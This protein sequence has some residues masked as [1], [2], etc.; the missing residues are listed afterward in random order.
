MVEIPFKAIKFNKCQ[1]FVKGFISKR[2][3]TF[4]FEVNLKLFMTS[5][6]E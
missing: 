6:L 5:F 2:H 3:V 4:N 1:K